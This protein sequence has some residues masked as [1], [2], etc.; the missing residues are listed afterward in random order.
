[1]QNEIKIGDM[2]LTKYSGQYINC[3]VVGIKKGLLF[4][5]YIT[6]YCWRDG[7]G[8]RNFDHLVRYRRQLITTNPKAD[9]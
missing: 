1:M 6:M 8:D 9:E 4:T 5:K 3:E 2:F 7:H